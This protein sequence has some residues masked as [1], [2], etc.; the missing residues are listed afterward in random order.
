MFSILTAQIPASSCF[1]NAGPG[2]QYA[3]PLIEQH[4]CSRLRLSTCDSSN[5][6][7]ATMGAY[8]MDTK[9]VF[10]G[11]NEPFRAPDA[12][13]SDHDNSE[14]L[15]VQLSGT[16]LIRNRVALQELVQK[17]LSVLLVEE[18]RSFCS[19]TMRRRTHSW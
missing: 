5:I 15:H 2:I 7:S 10:R 18:P 12:L 17:S 14:S 1:C 4:P 16:G 11:S 3:S 6:Q 9:M 13:E 8:D 19:P